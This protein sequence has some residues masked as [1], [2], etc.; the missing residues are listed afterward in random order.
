MALILV[1]SKE[2]DGFSM[3]SQDDRRM[4]VKIEQQSSK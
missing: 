4:D 3:I 1:E 2:F